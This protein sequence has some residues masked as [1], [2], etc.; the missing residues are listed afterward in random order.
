MTDRLSLA[1]RFWGKVHITADCWLWKGSR[2]PQGYGLIGTWKTDG[3]RTTV[4]AHRVA[5]ELVVGPIPD[6]L[7]LDHLCRVRH[8]VH[9]GHLEAVSRLE[10]MQRGSVALQT[11]CKRGHLFDEANTYKKPNGTRKC[12]A[13]VRI[14]RARYPARRRFSA[15]ERLAIFERDDYVCAICGEAIDPQLNWPHRLCATVDHIIPLRRGGTDEPDNLQ[16]A[17]RGCN[18]SKGRRLAD[19]TWG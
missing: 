15:E 2:N 3:L 12:R 4:G 11:H 6:G 18:V 9:P 13:C 10:N 1:A 17:H 7:E 5:Y 8:C 14:L 19:E 16:A